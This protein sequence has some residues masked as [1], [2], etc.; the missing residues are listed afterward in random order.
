MN[1]KHIAV[2]AVVVIV[3]ELLCDLRPLLDSRSE[4]ALYLSLSSVF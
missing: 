2:T 1:T 4:I 3:L